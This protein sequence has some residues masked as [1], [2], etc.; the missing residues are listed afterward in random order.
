MNHNRDR[1][2]GDRSAGLVRG[3]VVAIEV[4]VLA[5][6]RPDWWIDEA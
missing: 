1:E 2:P 3:R 4:A 6:P 5:A